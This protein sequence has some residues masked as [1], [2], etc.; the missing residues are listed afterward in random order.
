MR[1]LVWGVLL[2][3][4]PL[5]AQIINTETLRMHTHTTGWAGSASLSV[6]FSRNVKEILM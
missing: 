3:G 6:G 2:L 1:N 5:Q 4:F